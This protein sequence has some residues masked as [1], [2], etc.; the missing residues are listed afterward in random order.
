MLFLL[1]PDVHAQRLRELLVRFRAQ[2]QGMGAVLL[3]LQVE[4]ERQHREACYVQLDSPDAARCLLSRCSE[5]QAEC[6]L[7][8]I[9]LVHVRMAVAGTSEELAE[10]DRNTDANL[11]S[12]PA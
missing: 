4:L 11:L 5:L 12:T 8:A 10:H 1:D 2:E 7:L 9:E 3:D 6:D